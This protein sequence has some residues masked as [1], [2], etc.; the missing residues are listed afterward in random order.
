MYC[1]IFT[2]LPLY[3]FMYG[4]NEKYVAIPSVGES[5]LQYGEIMLYKCGSSEACWPSQQPSED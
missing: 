3:F 2:L 1:H 4:V 5:T